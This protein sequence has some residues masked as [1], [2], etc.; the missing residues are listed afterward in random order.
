[1]QQCSNLRCVAWCQNQNT[2]GVQPS[3]LS[4]GCSAVASDV[5]GCAPRKHV[6]L[7]GPAEL[8]PGASANPVLLVLRCAAAG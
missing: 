6:H 5:A 2:Q 7:T 8:K 3:S 1:L 4:E